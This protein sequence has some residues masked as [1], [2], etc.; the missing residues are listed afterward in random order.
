MEGAEELVWEPPGPGDW[1][2]DK[3]HVPRPLTRFTQEVA[4]EPFRRGFVETFRRYGIPVQD[5]LEG[6]VNGFSY[7]T[8]RGLDPEE[9]G[10]RAVAAEEALATRLW[11]ADLERWDTEVKPATIRRHRELI[12]VDVDAIPV[13]ALITHLRQCRDHVEAM[14]EQHHLF[15]GA[16]LL[17]LGDLLVAVEEWTDG[18]VTA[19]EVLALFAGTSPIS[20]G[21]CPELRDVLAALAADPR[22]T[23]RLADETA[24][25][26]E[27]LDALGDPEQVDEAAARA[28]REW[29]ALVGHRI[30]DGFDV[31]CPRAIERPTVLVS[32]LRNAAAVTREPAAPDVGAV[33]DRIPPEHREDF[34]ARYAESVRTYRLRDER[35]IYSD[36]TANGIMRRAMLAAGERLVAV[37]RLPRAELAVDAAVEELVALLDDRPEAPSVEDLEA[38]VRHRTTYTADDAPEHLGD[39]PGPRPPLELLP[40]AMGRLTK[41]MLMLTGNM[42][43]PEAGAETR[44]NTLTGIPASP[45]RHEG[46][47]RIVHTVDDLE[48]VEEGDVLVA[49]TTAES[50]NLAMSFAAAVVTDQ[51][52]LLGHAAITAREY[53][54]PAVVGTH[55]ATKAIADGVRVVVDGTTGEVSW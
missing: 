52:G 3:G 1:S 44:P 12:D 19:P 25:P 49:I 16:A 46:T 48:R 47:A 22:A 31:H 20:R 53:G 39:P 40:P 8:I 26:S 55:R 4:S 13:T 6:Y 7:G 17:P 11:R 34:D 2:L 18:A 14:I 38:R 41:A 45:G 9:F 50:F 33:R 5:M 42:G 35:G 51:G 54:I 32:C 24:D 21:D 23:A 30:L 15:N 43:A 28:V 27:V 10:A 36:A 29:V 37:G